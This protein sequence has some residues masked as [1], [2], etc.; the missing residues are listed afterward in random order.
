MASG[1][2]RQCDQMTRLLFNIWSFTIMKICPK[3][4]KMCQTKCAK[5][6]RAREMEYIEGASIVEIYGLKL[7]YPISLLSLCFDFFKAHNIL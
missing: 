6:Y 4:Q 7:V 3:A 1:P 5:H 2:L